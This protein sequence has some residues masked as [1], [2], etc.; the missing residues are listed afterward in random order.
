MVQAIQ[1]DSTISHPVTEIV[2]IASR[3]SDEEFAVN[4]QD[5]R[6]LVLREE[7]LDE[8]ELMELIEAPTSN[9]LAKH[10]CHES[11]SLFS[12]RSNM[13]ITSLT[14]IRHFRPN[15]N[16]TSQTRGLSFR[17]KF[18]NNILGYDTASLQHRLLLHCKP[19]TLDPSTNKNSIDLDEIGV[20]ATIDWLST[21]N[22]FIRESF[23]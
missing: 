11:G 21:K 22:T 20:L 15:M 3:L 12:S 13:N 10:G 9:A 7:T 14:R 4:H 6:E 5:V 17:P 23:I 1:D 19:K 16:I 8:D 2:N 18:T